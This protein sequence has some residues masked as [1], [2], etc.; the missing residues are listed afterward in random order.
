MSTKLANPAPLGLM[1]F[2]MTTILLNIHNAGFFPMDSMILAMGIFYGGL[3]QVIVGIMCYKRGDT[4]GTTAFTS[5]G[6][7]WLT[8]VGLIVMPHMGLPASPASFMGWYLALWGI[9]TGFMFI[10]SLCY[11][12]AKQV[13]FGSLTILFFLLAARDFTGSEFIGTVAGFEG[14][15]CGASAIYFAMAQVLNNEFGREVLPVGKAKIARKVEALAT[16]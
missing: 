5:Y 11:P 12:T 6:L 16:A 13:V 7:F 1:G 8:L 9:F 4:F 10:G 3:G 2:G 15:F 14:I